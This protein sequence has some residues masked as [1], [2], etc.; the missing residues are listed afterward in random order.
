[1]IIKGLIHKVVLINLYIYIF[2]N[3]FVEFSSRSCW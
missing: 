1:M 2:H 3:K